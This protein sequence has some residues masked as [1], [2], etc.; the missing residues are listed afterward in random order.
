MRHPNFVGMFEN[1]GEFAKKVL[2]HWAKGFTAEECANELDYE[3][4]KEDFDF[5]VEMVDNMYHLLDIQ[6][7]LDFKNLVGKGN[8]QQAKIDK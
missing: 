8:L 6:Q 5:L 7:E 2:D 4:F 3:G 1:G